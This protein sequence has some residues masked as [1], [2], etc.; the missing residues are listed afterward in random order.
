MLTTINLRQQL[1]RNGLSNLIFVNF[2]GFSTAWTL[3]NSSSS[4]G[5]STGARFVVPV[6]RGSRRSHLLNGDGELQ[7]RCVSSYLIL[8]SFNLIFGRPQFQG[9][10]EICRCL[11]GRW[12]FVRG[13][14]VIGL[15][16]IIHLVQ[17]TLIQFLKVLLPE[18][19]LLI[20]FLN[21]WEEWLRIVAGSPIDGLMSL[22]QV[23]VFDI[24]AE[25]GLLLVLA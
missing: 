4:A 9:W 17:R 15:S 21:F 22:A 3:M 8:I 20:L 11:F 12:R 24:F 18:H 13:T 23:V 25:H 1:M 16:P 6:S 19:N 2:A 7:S 14:P 5:R 10:R